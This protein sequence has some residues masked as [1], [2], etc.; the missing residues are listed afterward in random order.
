MKK[1]VSLKDIY[2][3]QTLFEAMDVLTTLKEDYEIPIRVKKSDMRVMLTEFYDY[4]A[5]KQILY[6]YPE[7]M[8]GHMEDIALIAINEEVE[9]VTMD[10]V[11]AK[12]RLLELLDSPTEVIPPETK[13]VIQKIKNKIEKGPKSYERKHH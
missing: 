10:F 8:I 1:L 4:Y 3:K 11:L 7:L 9:E 6:H 2:I 5:Q 12:M 13:R